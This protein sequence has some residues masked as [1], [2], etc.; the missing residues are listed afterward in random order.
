MPPLPLLKPV[1]GRQGIRAFRV[2]G[3]SASRQPHHSHEARPHRHASVPDY[4]HVAQ[5]T[6]RALI[7]QSGVSVDDFLAALD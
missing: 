5:G 7:G 2:A 4:A 1:R 6:L 3:G